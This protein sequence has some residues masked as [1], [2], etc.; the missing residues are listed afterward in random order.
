M[1]SN[2]LTVKVSTIS[3][4]KFFS[5]MVDEATDVSNIERLSFCVRSVD[6]NLDVS[7]DFIGFYEIYNIK[8]EIIINA[9]KDILLKF[10][11]NLGDCHGQTHDQANSMMGKRSGVSTQIL[12]GQPKV[13]A[14]SATLSKSG[15]QITHERLYNSSWCNGD[16]GERYV[17]VKYSPRREKMLESIVENIEEE[18]ETSSRSDNQK[19][20]NFA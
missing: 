11:L 9:I 19:L 16:L 1:A 8:S 6:D 2:V 4:R 13:M 7:E 15:N 5:I 14:L 18:F 12:V 17:L 3:K 10:H 20:D